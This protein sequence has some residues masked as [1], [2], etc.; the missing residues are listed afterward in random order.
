[1]LKYE[2]VRQGEADLRDAL[3]FLLPIVEFGVFQLESCLLDVG[4][5][6]ECS[7][8]CRLEVDIDERHLGDSLD[9]EGRSDITTE[10]LIQLL[11]LRG[12]RVRVPGPLEFLLHQ[13]GLHV[14]GVRTKRHLLNDAV[15]DGAIELAIQRNR[16]STGR[17]GALGLQNRVIQP[18]DGANQRELLGA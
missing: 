8:L 7:G 14:E 11:L 6:P 16:V 5:V 17:D 9:L 10:K 3:R 18:L 12:E 1:M 4:A 13:V 2:R 15:L